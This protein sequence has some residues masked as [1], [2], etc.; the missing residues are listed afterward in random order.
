MVATS[1]DSER[2]AQVLARLFDVFDQD[3]NNAVDFSELASGL[4]S[5]AADLAMR[6]PKQRLRYMT[7]TVMDTFHSRDDSYLT[8]VFKVMYE[9]QL[10]TRACGVERHQSLLR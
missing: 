4:S 7:T 10:H 3:G 9:T 1:E 8:S 2:T 6:R 5:F